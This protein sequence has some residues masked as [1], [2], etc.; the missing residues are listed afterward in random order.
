M[1]L[2]HSSHVI[3]SP[4]SFGTPHMPSSGSLNVVI[5]TKTP[6]YGTCRVPKDVAEFIKCEE[7]I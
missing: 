2:M 5:T 1:H 7:Y 3:I 4:T 6:D